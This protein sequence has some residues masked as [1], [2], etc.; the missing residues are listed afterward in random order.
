MHGRTNKSWK[1]LAGA[2]YERLGPYMR[3]WLPAP[4]KRRLFGLVG[5]IESRL[6]IG[7]ETPEA[8]LASVTPLLAPEAFARG[9]IVCINNGLAWGG[10]ERQLVNTLIGLEARVQ[11]RVILLCQKLG[12]HADYDFY[13]PALRAQFSG[14]VRNFG[15]LDAARTALAAHDLSA[16]ERAMAWLPLD[17]RERILRLMAEFSALRPAIVHAWQDALSIEA[18]YA[19]ALTGVPRIVLSTRNVA[20][21]AF[22]YH[23]PYMRAA[24][25]E[26]AALAHVRLINNSEAGARDY[27]RW[28]GLPPN[29]IGVLR[30]GF[31]PE[32]RASSSL[33][34][35]LNIPADAPL[36]G[37]V[38]RFYEEKRPLL[39]VEAAAHIA[40][41]MP[42]AHFVVLGAGPLLEQARALAAQRGFAQRLRTPGA[43][44]GAAQD[45]AAFDVFLLTSAFEGTPNVILEASALGVPV[46]TTGA[47]GAP[48]A[49]QADVTGRVVDPPTPE[50]LAHAVVS[51]FH[52]GAFRARCAVQAPRFI[53]DRF[54]I[55]RMIGETLALYA[56]EAG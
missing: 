48:E 56:G 40:T 4:V 17:V 43:E 16:A 11:R 15:S 21:P 47:G 14:E 1:S 28:L 10:A 26:L 18:G 7:A 22:A 8:P 52:D 23:R 6:S 45:I 41:Q 24:Y 51:L 55:D 44:S 50:A 3:R 53:E 29:T 46:V 49:I 27:E 30:N 9:P 13:L 25:R 37:S 5:A 33:R 42:E 36:I 2:A 31:R 20:A 35:R 12:E 39:W 34:A 38:F 54:G 32:P 19:A